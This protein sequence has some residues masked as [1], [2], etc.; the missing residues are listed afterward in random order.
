M[1]NPVRV[2][3]G[4][5]QLKLVPDLVV[6]NIGQLITLDFADGAGISGPLRGQDLDRSEAVSDGIL[7]CGQG[8]VIATGPR[9]EVRL[10]LQRL[11]VSIDSIERV[12]AE[13]KAVIPGFVDPHTHLVFGRTRQDEYE[14]RIRGESY[15]EIAAAGGGIMSSV[16]DMR[17]R[18]ESELLA[19]GSRRVREM[20]STGTLTVEVK[21]GYGL[22]LTNELKM[23]RVARQIGHDTGVRLVA[24]CLAA[25]EYPVEYRERHSEYVDLVMNEILPEV[26]ENSLA[27]RA[28]VFCEP[29]VFDLQDTRAILEC[30]RD[31]G[32][33]LTVHADELEAF[34]G[35]ALAAELNARSADHLIRI[36]S[37][38][39]AALAA[40]S[41]VA[42]LLPGTVFSLGLETYAPARDM[43]AAG[44]A[45]ALASDFNPGSSPISSMPLIQSI[46]C[47]QMRLTPAESLAGATLNAAW[48]LGLQE[49]TG[50]LSPGKSADFLVLDCDDFRLISYHAG[51]NPVV[52]AF[53]RGLKI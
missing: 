6:E 19:L 33:D 32:L 15:L 18:S 29:T 37:T 21:S 8:V 11:G 46:A 27:T 20:M 39:I 47:T 12:D 31:L 42:V 45:L 26:A 9:K 28:D 4:L 2:H 38:G 52:A 36:D 24:T 22:D 30:A 1:S 7:V 43:I 34:G 14:R 41:T 51:H 5:D 48:A 13:G 44:C 17:Q 23:L 3:Q 49:I 40:S 10:E 53:L 35:A 50:S 25:H 16:G